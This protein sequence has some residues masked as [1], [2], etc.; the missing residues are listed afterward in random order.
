MSAYV[1][2][3]SATKLRHMRRYP[4]L[5]V[6]LV[7]MPIVLLLVFVYVFGGTRAM[8]IVRKRATMPSVMSMLT[9]HVLGSLIQTMLSM[10]VV[11]GVALSRSAW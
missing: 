5:T 7:G 8:A 4:S 3:D 6:M 2:T 9:G 10:V 11:V 1:M